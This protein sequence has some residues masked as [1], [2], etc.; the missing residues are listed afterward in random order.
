M[1]KLNRCNTS[2][3]IGLSALAVLTCLVCGC[4]TGGSANGSGTSTIVADVGEFITA[5][6]RQHLSAWLF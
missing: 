5:V 4:D 2:L 1:I 3:A 6:A